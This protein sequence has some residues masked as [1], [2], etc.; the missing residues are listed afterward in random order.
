MEKRRCDPC[1][2]SSSPPIKKYDIFLSFR[3]EDTRNNFTGHLSL[4]LRKVG[5]FNIFKDDYALDKG[6]EIGPELLN[7]IEASHYAVVVLSENYADSHWCLKELAKIVDCMGDSGRIR[8]IFYHV[9]PSDV[10]NQKGSFG[11]AMAKHEEDSRHSSDDVQSW[12]NALTKVANQSGEPIKKDEKYVFNL[13][14][15]FH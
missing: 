9:D 4:A 5:L 11:K 3:G 7:A 13:L 12:R 2:S 15:F 6:K 10:R 14:L 8:T 1:S